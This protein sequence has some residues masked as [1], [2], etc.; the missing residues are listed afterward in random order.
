MTLIRLVTSEF[1]IDPA[2]EVTLRHLRNIWLQ[3][4]YEIHISLFILSFSLHS[5]PLLLSS[6]HIEECT[7]DLHEV[8]E[9][10]LS[11]CHQT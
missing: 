1:S 5:Y 10:E 11:S 7:Y 6:A 3:R 9:W 2:E 4:S 8:F